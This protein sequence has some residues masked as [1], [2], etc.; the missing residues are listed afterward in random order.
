M[1]RSVAIAAALV[2][3]AICGVVH[4]LRAERWQTSRALEEA[5][6]RVDL[7]PLEI[8][9]WKAERETSAKK[10]ARD[11]VCPSALLPPIGMWRPA[12]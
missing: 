8:G 2:L 3:I 12:R 9:D 10:S 4:G 11:H 1:P 7:A 5:I 6:A